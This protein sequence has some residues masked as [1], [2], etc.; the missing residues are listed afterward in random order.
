MF[1]RSLPRV[2]LL[3]HYHNRACCCCILKHSGLPGTWHITVGEWAICTK[4]QAT[5]VPSHGRL[6]QINQ[7]HLEFDGS[8]VGQPLPIHR[9]RW[10]LHLRKQL[11]HGAQV[12]PPAGRLGNQNR[13]RRELQ[14]CHSEETGLQSLRL[15]IE[16]LHRRH[17]CVLLTCQDVKEARVCVWGVRWRSSSLLCI[18]SKQ[19]HPP[20]MLRRWR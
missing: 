5:R 14:S 17:C 3:Q 16:L 10:L 9:S 12:Q 1:K 6:L 11:C 19:A 13:R 15:S 20:W 7:A 8:D 2:S 4:M 18:R